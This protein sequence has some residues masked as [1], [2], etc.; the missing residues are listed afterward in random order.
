MRATGWI[1]GTLLAGTVLAD[2][3]SKYEMDFEFIRDTVRQHGAAVK[4]A[5]PEIAAQQAFLA[6]TDETFQAS[7]SDKKRLLAK[8]KTSA[9]ARFAKERLWR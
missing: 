6:M 9:I 4:S 5:K 2:G 8:Y 3:S 7:D 1:L